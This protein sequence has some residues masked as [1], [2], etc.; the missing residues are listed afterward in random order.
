MKSL[1]ASVCRASEGRVVRGERRPSLQK[2]KASLF[3]KAD[4]GKRRRHAHTH[5]YINP[6]RHMHA[7]IKT[8]FQMTQ[9][10]TQIHTRCPSRKHSLQCGLKLSDVVDQNNM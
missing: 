9:Q 7:N 8:E 1:R 5:T 6:R 10:L 4:S 3:H 2:L